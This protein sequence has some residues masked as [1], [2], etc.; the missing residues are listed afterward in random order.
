VEAQLKPVKHSAQHVVQTWP[1][2]MNA[3]VHPVARKTSQA[4]AIAQNVAICS[5][6]FQSLF[7]QSAEQRICPAQSSA[8]LVA[9][10]CPEMK[11]LTTVW[12]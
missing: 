5:V 7:A 4:T 11:K 2:I 12:T 1:K 3:N 10:L 9:H 6:S 8:F